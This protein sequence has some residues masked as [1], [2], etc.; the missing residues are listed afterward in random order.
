M[1]FGS[2]APVLPFFAGA[3]VAATKTGCSAIGTVSAG[4]AFALGL[5]VRFGAGA[6]G[7]AS[8]TAMLASTAS[9]FAALALALAFSLAFLLRFAGGAAAL[10]VSAVGASVDAIEPASGS[11][12]TV[13]ES[14]GES[15]MI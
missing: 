2:A 11:S 4:S 9:S 14:L 7:A 12:L 8:A 6:A 3:A 5:R 13:A 1:V 15:K 10:S